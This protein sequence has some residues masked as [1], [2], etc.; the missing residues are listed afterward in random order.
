M[1]VL[2][3]S[4]FYLPGYK[5]G[6]PIK[7]LKNLFDSSV[8]E[9][10]FKL[11]TSDRDL[12]DCRPY[13]SVACGEW[14]AVGNVSVFY[15]QPGYRGL[16]QSVAILCERS[17]DIVYLNS[18]FSIRF[19]LLPLLI[20]KL[21]NRKVILGPRGEFSEG[22]LNI[23]RVRKQIFIAVY[24]VLGLHR[25]TV[26]QA[27]TEFET[28]DIRRVLGFDVN[29]IVAEDIGSMEF[30]DRIPE[31]S[32]GSLK[33][34][35]VSRISPKKNLLFAL[36]ALKWVKCT[37]Q[38]D[39]YGPIESDSYWENCRKAMEALPSYVKV[40]YM[41]EL[42]PVDVLQKMAVYDF[43]F[44][45]T[46]GENY[47][48]VIAEAFCAGLP[49]LISDQTPWR[50]LSRHRLGWDLPLH[51][52]KVFANA[53]DEL[54]NMT[55]DEHKALRVSVLSWARN[56]FSQSAA[57]EANIAMFRNVHAYN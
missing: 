28:L 38:Y 50:E 6:G 7:T 5:G 19:S 25:R 46:K 39:I 27:S 49:V 29:I 9:V 18:F 48:H 56:R 26:F 45:P 30:V 1:D 15:S 31:R 42:D 37:V 35:F 17:Y 32:L 52:P 23:K 33:G 43:F 3:F 53:I 47:G 14:N 24:K 12:R 2:A 11:V 36:E 10:S 22:A 55:M 8:G 20:S 51:D 41:G 13:G 21:L 54:A 40:N 16:L 44:F 57:I 34:V 4:G